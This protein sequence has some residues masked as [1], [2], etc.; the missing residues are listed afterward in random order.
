[1]S[2]EACHHFLEPK[3]NQHQGFFPW[4]AE[5]VYVHLLT[6][7]ALIIFWRSVSYNTTSTTS[8]VAFFQHHFCSIIFYNIVSTPPLQHC[9][10]QQHFNIAFMQH[11][12]LQHRFY[13]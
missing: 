2:W 12:L 10:L 3:K 6:T 4:V 5:E 13:S 11:C 7:D 8:S 9:L 1:M